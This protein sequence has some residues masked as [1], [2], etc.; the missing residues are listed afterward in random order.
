MEFM[1]TLTEH[2]YLALSVI[3]LYARSLQP[4]F[5][6]A[7]AKLNWGMYSDPKWSAATWQTP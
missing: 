2:C 5:E 4:R 3:M 1:K 6:F 7:Q